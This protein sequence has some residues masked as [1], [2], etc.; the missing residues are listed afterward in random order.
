MIEAQGW[1]SRFDI[2][3][4]TKH[5]IVLY[6]N[7]L[8]WVLAG[9]ER[10]TLAQWIR[11]RLVEQYG[12]Q[13]V[14]R[15]N[16]S[17]ELRVLY[18]GDLSPQQGS[19][20]LRSLV[21]GQARDLADP[22]TALRLMRAVLRQ[23]DQS[24]AV[25]IENAEHRLNNQSAEA[26]LLR[27][28]VREGAD[29]STVRGLA[30]HLYT[31]DSQIPQDFITA[32]ADTALILVSLPS[33]SERLEFLKSLPAES[34]LIA[35]RERGVAVKLER[36]AQI[37]EGYRLRELDQLAALADNQEPGVGLSSLLSLFRHG[38]KIDPWVNREVSAIKDALHRRVQG[39]DRAVDQVIK[40][41]Y[42]AKQR[43]D[44]LI[45]DSVRSPAM[46]LFFVGATGV[47]KTLMARAICEAITG[48]EENLKR[49]DMSEYQREHTDQRLIGPPPGYVGHL[50]GGQLTNWVLERPQS[51]V[52]IDEVEKAHERILDIFIQI[53]AAYRRQGSDSRYERDHT[54]LYQQYRG[55]RSDGK[56][57][58]QARQRSS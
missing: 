24:G 19:D 10:L 17:E 45:E 30:I 28:L 33:Y 34:A 23:E 1:M 51:V 15:Y 36:L 43:V 39:Q 38:R 22:A 35:T 2:S 5:R 18:W 42:R 8:D 50:E 6:G 32:D 41:V 16:H 46:V 21:Q 58:R 48:T 56:A 55:R 37:T 25:L 29:G 13:R 54:D 44:S 11:R 53:L 47:G 4:Q 9:D 7:V 26:V 12:F 14:L 20:A 52:L 57:T 31:S 3:A 40:S 49:I 27:Q